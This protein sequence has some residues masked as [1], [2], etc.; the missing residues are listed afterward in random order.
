MSTTAKD[1]M[2]RDVISVR[3]DT[4]VNDLIGVFLENKI[5]CAPVLD[6]SD[7]LVGIVTKTDVIGHFMDLDLDLTFQVAIKDLIDLETR[8]NKLDLK[9]GGDLTVD[10]IMT[11]KPIVA[12]EKH[13]IQKLAQ[14]MIKNRIHRLIITKGNKITGI[15]STL[16]IISYVAGTK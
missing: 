9:M 6:E 4:K 12:K 3:K 7:N 13:T 10:D 8:V 1:I 2:T 15:V 5:S 14:T 11:H 16:D